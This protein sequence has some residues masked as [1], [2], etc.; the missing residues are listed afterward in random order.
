MRG[1][2]YPMNKDHARIR[3]GVRHMQGYVP[4]E[5]PRIANLVKLN[6]NEN[7]YP[8]APGVMAL[9]AALSPD[10]LRRYPPPACDGLRDCV[11][12]LY[13]FNA[14]SVFCGNGSDEILALC[15]RAFVECGRKI[16]YFEPSYSL[17]PVLAAIAESDVV[18]VALGEDFGWV[19]PPLDAGM[20]LFYL[21]NPNA[22]TGMRFPL[23]AVTAFCERFDGVVV[24]DEAYVDFSEANCLSLARRLPNVIVSRSLSKS[25]S[26]A[27]LRVGYAMGAA[28]L[29]Q[30][31]GKIKDSYNL[32][33]VAQ[34]LAE[35]ALQDQTYMRE[36]VQRIRLTRERLS[37]ALV[38]RGFSVY[39]SETNFVWCKPPTALA[40]QV[41]TEALRA[42]GI[43]IRHF[44]TERLAPFV[45]ITVGLDAQMEYFIETTDEILEGYHG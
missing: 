24:I 34:R 19:D 42:R 44:A 43:L 14:D 26:L 35:A 21:T 1:E 23:D 6:T 16:G 41:Y 32:D 20:D 29:I 30:A 10:V 3:A 12:G 39:P 22:P 37:K 38:V 7:P 15:T 45:R 13:D 4:G 25:Y 31:L 2:E 36:N 28:E 17:Y 9:L 8:P 11:A 33:I 27:G 18:E 40:A 5:Q